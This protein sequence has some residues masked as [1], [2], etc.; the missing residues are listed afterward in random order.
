MQKKLAIP[1][2]RSCIL[3][4]GMHEKT[5]YSMITVGYQDYDRIA[6]T[7]FLDARNKY[8]SLQSV[9]ELCAI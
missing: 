4:L 8:F 3:V 6:W 9:V 1:G 7:L 5:A 2:T